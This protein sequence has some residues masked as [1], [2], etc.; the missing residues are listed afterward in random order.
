MNC[1]IMIFLLILSCFSYLIAQETI[2]DTLYSIPDLDGDIVYDWNSGNYSTLIY[3]TCI[4][5]GDYGSWD[6]GTFRGYLAFNLPEIPDGYELISATIYVDQYF[7]AGN[8]ELDIFPIWDVTPPPDTLGC[9]VDHINYGNQLNIDDW[10]AGDI[11]DP[12]TITSNIGELSNNANIEFKSLLVTSAV[13]ADYQVN[14]DITQYRLRFLID[15]DWDQQD[16]FLMFHTGNAIGDYKPYLRLEWSDEVSIGEGELSPEPIAYL[17][18]FPNPFKENISITY[19]LKMQSDI[20]STLEIYNVKGQKVFSKSILNERG[21][22]NWQCQE[23]SSGIYLV[24]ISNS[25]NQV[26]KKISFIK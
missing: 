14:R 18:S 26:A 19:N 23:N 11:G 7:S 24:K 1:K 5:V 9:I 12:Q 8:S 21:T 25:E 4:T 3:D 17:T 16:D 13:I 2:I 10:T 15:N 6:I 22:I 20:T